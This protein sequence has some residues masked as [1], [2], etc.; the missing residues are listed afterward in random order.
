M[1]D[2]IIQVC[3]ET[4]RRQAAE[5]AEA[6]QAA[7][8]SDVLDESAK[9]GDSQADVFGNA[10]RGNALT[11]ACDLLRKLACDILF[12]PMLQLF[13]QRTSVSIISWSFSIIM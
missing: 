4:L 1:R 2:H 7:P 11:A 6:L 5:E 10:Q 3:N 8:L 13:F 12:R 9:D